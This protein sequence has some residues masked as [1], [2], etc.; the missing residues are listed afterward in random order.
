MY[1]LGNLNTVLENNLSTDERRH[2]SCEQQFV[3]LRQKP[4]TH[5]RPGIT[6]GRLC[7][8]L[9]GHQ[10]EIGEVPR[11]PHTGSEQAQIDQKI[12]LRQKQFKNCLSRKCII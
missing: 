2:Q 12:P 10:V 9:R 1:I 4:T 3:W 7:H 8:R 11:D 6:N 5:H